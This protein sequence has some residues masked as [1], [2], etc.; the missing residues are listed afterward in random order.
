MI[1]ELTEAKDAQLKINTET[2]QAQQQRPEGR[3]SRRRRALLQRMLE[4]LAGREGELADSMLALIERLEEESSR[5]FSFM[6]KNVSADMQQVR[7]LLLELETDS[8]TQFLQKGVVVDIERMIA[9]LEEQLEVMKRQQQQ[10]QQQQ[11]Q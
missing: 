4:P 2:A 8:F 1:K 6:L 5:V 10:Q 7:D 3:L 11:Q 9:S